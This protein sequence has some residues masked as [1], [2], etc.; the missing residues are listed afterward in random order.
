MF[1][2]P[3]VLPIF[4]YDSTATRAVDRQRLAGGVSRGQLQIS[5]L[6]IAGAIAKSIYANPTPAPLLKASLSAMALASVQ[7]LSMSVGPTRNLRLC[8]Q[9]LQGG[10]GLR[11]FSRTARVGEYGQGVCTL[12][13]QD[14][15]GL[16]IVLDFGVLCTLLGAA[17]P[18][19]QAT[20]LDFAG[21]SGGDF[22]LVESKSSFDSISI[23]TELREGLLQCDAG[24]DHLVAQ[25]AMTPSGSF[26]VLTTFQAD[27][28]PLDSKIQFADPTRLGEEPPH[29][30]HDRIAR[31]YYVSALQALGVDRE[32]A[33]DFLAVSAPNEYAEDP[34]PE[35]RRRL[36]PVAAAGLPPFLRLT[37]ELASD[38]VTGYRLYMDEEVLEA[39]RRGEPRPF[40]LA[41]EHWARDYSQALSALGDSDSLLTVWSDG[42]VMRLPPRERSSRS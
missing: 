9:H 35:L 34:L 24:V 19:G 6:R 20:Q 28:G 33:Q 37:G 40:A 16:P 32:R 30:V 15:L 2:L 12:F 23:K 38:Q 11:D 4:E 26:A 10:H 39:V 8:A 41:T 29:D 1:V 25:G 27:N 3:T 7:W 18:N 31:H 36:V 17:P 14:Y 13:M 21:W 42:L 5:S 22:K